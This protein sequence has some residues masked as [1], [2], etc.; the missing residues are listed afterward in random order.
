MLRTY[1]NFR[2]RTIVKVVENGK[3]IKFVTVTFSNGKQ[4]VSIVKV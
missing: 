1:D 2:N 4:L 3:E